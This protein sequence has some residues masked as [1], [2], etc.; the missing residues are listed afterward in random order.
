MP[1]PVLLKFSSIHFPLVLISYYIHLL[2]TCFIIVL[3]YY[4]GLTYVYLCML[5]WYFMLCIVTLSVGIVILFILCIVW[6][7]FTPLSNLIPCYI[8]CVLYA[9]IS[10]VGDLYIPQFVTLC[11]WLILLGYAFVSVLLIFRRVFILVHLKIILNYHIFK[12][13]TRLDSGCTVW[14]NI[15]TCCTISVYFLIMDANFDVPLS[16]VG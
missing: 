11:I 5:S 4:Y 16:C 14:N 13:Y 7:W 6:T 12:C 9:S 8:Y 2:M 3:Y 1:I 15:N 10:G